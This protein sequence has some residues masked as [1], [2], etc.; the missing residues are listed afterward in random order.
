MRRPKI[1]KPDEIAPESEIEQGLAS[2]NFN[3]AGT[4]RHNDKKESRRYDADLRGVI[5]SGKK[6]ATTYR[7]QII[8]LWIKQ[9]SEDSEK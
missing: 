6:Y 3:V 5:E 2:G 4:Y 7:G 9:D 8:L 1:P